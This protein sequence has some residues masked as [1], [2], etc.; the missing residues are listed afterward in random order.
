M[1][2]VEELSPRMVDILGKVAMG[3]QLKAQHICFQSHRESFYVYML[4]QNKELWKNDVMIFE[5]DTSLKLM[6]LERNIKTTPKVVFIRQAEYPEMER[7]IWAEAE[8][9]KQQEMMELDQQFLEIAEDNLKNSNVSTI[10][11][12]GDG[13]KEGWAKESLKLLCKNRRVFQGNNLYSKGACYGML[14][15][16]NP[17]AEWKENVYLGVDKLKS[18]IGIR[19]LRQG[20]ESYYAILDA[21]V[22]WYEAESEF[23]VILESGNELK[24]VITPLTGGNVTNRVVILEGLPERPARTTRLNVHIEM[25]AVDQAAITVEDM[26]FGEL[27]P[28][29]GKAWTHNIS[30]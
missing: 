28:S 13:F 27:F 24:F 12:L 9:E 6:H 19:V 14:E 5:Y 1:F 22:N 21:G 29:S 4:H 7:K 15:R 16:M 25:T 17:S 3:L 2:T 8:N 26:G 11:L 18:N 30:V 10:F 20:K 23:D